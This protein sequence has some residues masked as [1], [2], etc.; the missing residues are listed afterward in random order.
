MW[1]TTESIVPYLSG[2]SCNRRQREGKR[3]R[4]NLR[5][6]IEK[7]EE[8]EMPHQVTVTGQ[9]G[10]AKVLTTAVVANVNE[11]TFVPDPKLLRLKTNDLPGVVRDFDVSAATTVTCVITTGNYAFTIS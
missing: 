9:V 4:I 7:K 10:P 11:V 3:T 1:F 6:V 2:V 5:S 8:E